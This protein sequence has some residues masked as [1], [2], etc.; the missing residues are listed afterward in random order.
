MSCHCTL[1]YLE[2]LARIVNAFYSKKG[3][4]VAGAGNGGHGSSASH[5]GRRSSS[6]VCMVPMHHMRSCLAFHVN[7]RNPPPPTTSMLPR[8]RGC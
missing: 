3:A 2:E 7:T 8:C 5:G 6:S 4:M 1:I